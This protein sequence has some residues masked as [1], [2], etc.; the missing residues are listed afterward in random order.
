MNRA[1]AIACLAAAALAV[2]GCGLGDEEEG[3]GSKGSLQVGLLFPTSGTVA[4]AG[5]DMLHGWQLWFK[6][7]GD[8]VAGRKIVAK[9]E[10]TAG[11]PTLTLTKARKLVQQNNAKLTVGPLLANEAYALAGY[12]KQ[13]PDVIG[14]NPAGSSDDLSQ[15]KRVENFVRTGGWQ[16]STPAQPAGDWAADQGWKRA[17]TLCSDYAFGYENCGG[18]VNTF[19]DR[20]GKIVKQLYAPIGTSDYSSYLAQIDPNSVDGVFVQSVGADAPRFVKAWSDLGLKG[21][22]PLIVNET[23]LEQSTLRGVKGDDPV[24]LESFAH[25]AEGRQETATSE[26]VAAYEKEYGELPGYYSCSTY[27]AA[28]WLTEA[29]KQLD[30][31]IS[32]S[33]K[34]LDTLNSVKLKDTCFG[35]MALDEHG[36]TIANV[37]LRKVARNDKGQLVNQ[38]VKSYPNVSQFWNYKPEE[39]LKQPV[40]SRKDQG[41]DWPTSCDAYAKD[42]PLKEGT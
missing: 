26:F 14:L 35:P 10:D 18:F 20:G 6:L 11:D 38:V 19:T 9:H 39:F 15:R 41:K 40:Y 25:Y 21:K 28:Q 37:Y 4:A 34:F 42:C 5:T 16:S 32:D 27:T 8:E 3:G 36:G 22:V 29:I 13:Q 24:G 23:T 7:H 17:V 30:G 31:D 1:P 33:K 12:L 2:G